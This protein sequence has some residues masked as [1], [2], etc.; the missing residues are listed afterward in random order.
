M[1][2]VSENAAQTEANRF[3]KLAKEAGRKV[4]RACLYTSHPR[5]ADFGCDPDCVRR[6]IEK[7]MIGLKG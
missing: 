6:N 5:I 2:P 4:S 3:S 7:P 1:G